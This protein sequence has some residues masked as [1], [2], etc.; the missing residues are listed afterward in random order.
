[1]ATRAAAAS[2]HPPAAEAATQAFLV[3]PGDAPA[4]A[5][6][7]V[8]AGV[9]ALA[10]RHASVLLSSGTIL[11]GG[12]GEGLLAIDGRARQPGLEAPR[13]RGFTD[14]SAV[15]DAAKIAAP[16]WP[17]ALMLAHAGRG[18]RTRTAMM[19][20]GLT[21]ARAASSIDEARVESLRAFGREGGAILRAGPIREAL[22]A[23]GARSLGGTL[24]RED[25]DALRAELAPA[26]TESV[27]P[28]TWARA[29]WTDDDVPG[30]LAIVAACDTHGAF[31]IASI[32]IPTL[33]APLPDVGLAVP[34]LARPVL[35]GVTRE[36][37]GSPLPLAAPIGVSKSGD[38]VDL[39][40]GVSGPEA[41]FVELM[42]RVGEALA[43]DDALASDHRIAGVMFDS[44]AR[45]RA[46]SR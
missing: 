25:L 29:P 3:E 30:E 33:T 4:T 9:M 39:A 34:L 20:L 12:T 13:P 8:L 11:L 22:L 37:A 27:G 46:L 41:S 5:I 10:A 14:A 31:A 19:N 2:T 40:V 1:M 35:R 21:A 24:T 36:A 7:A 38:A 6:D 23:A 42:N 28:R 32:L 17:A 15:P 45:G 44:R 26:R 18:V 43:I 16:L